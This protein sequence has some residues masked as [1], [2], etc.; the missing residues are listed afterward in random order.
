MNKWITRIIIAILVIGA[1]AGIGIAAYRIGYN[2]GA[3]ATGV[4][5]PH[6]MLNRFDRFDRNNMP[7]FHPGV[8]DQSFKQSF[9]HS[10]FST[11]NRGRNIGFFSPF[12]FLF[13]IAVFGLLI[14]IGYKLF[15][16]NGWQLSFTRQPANNEPET[17]IESRK[18]TKSSK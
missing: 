10:Q 14:W 11:L 4:G 7:Q 18:S 1:F 5:M 6:Q 3:Q 15:T 17:R 12:H 8:N 16:G 2:Q 9:G 13:R